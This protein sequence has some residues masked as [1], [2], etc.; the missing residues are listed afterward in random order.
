M[1]KD[2]EE[3]FNMLEK[4]LID[5]TLGLFREGG[6]ILTEKQAKNIVGKVGVRIV[7]GGDDPKEKERVTEILQS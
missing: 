1:D 2:T 7:F 3:I 5:L 4:S 6:T